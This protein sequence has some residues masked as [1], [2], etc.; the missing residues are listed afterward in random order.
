MIVIDWKYQGMD[1]METV[2]HIRQMVGKV[3]TPIAMSACDWRGM[4]ARTRTPGV[5]YFINNRVQP[6]H[7]RDMLF[8]ATHHRRTYDVLV[9][10]QDVIFSH[11]YI[12]IAEDKDLKNRDDSERFRSQGIC[13]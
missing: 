1:D 6:E 10:P 11:E 2:R 5:D 3:K 12:L 7:L 9:I 4:E 8:L 13:P